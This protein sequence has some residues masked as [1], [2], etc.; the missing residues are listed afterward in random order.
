MPYLRLVSCSYLR[1]YLS[2]YPKYPSECYKLTDSI[3]NAEFLLT[4]SEIKREGD[5]RENQSKR[6]V[7]RA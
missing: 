1:T 2:R 4:Q 7:G 3:E 5:Y 6:R